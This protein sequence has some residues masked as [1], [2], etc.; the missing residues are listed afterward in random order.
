MADMTSSQEE[1]DPRM[2]T[3]GPS[4]SQPGKIDEQTVT[5]LR[6]N[7]RDCYMS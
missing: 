3:V 7:I 4:G 2:L 6:L 5:T 1:L